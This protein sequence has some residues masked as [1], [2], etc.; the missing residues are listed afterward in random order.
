LHHP[1]RAIIALRENK[2]GYMAELAENLNTLALV[3]IGWFNDPDVLFAVFPRC[4]LLPRA[5]FGYLRKAVHK[6]S[7][8]TVI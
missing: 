2:V 8:F 1:V 3:G 4:A 6:V 5:T 7:D